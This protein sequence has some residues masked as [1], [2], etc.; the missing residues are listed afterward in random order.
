MVDDTSGD[1]SNPSGHVSV[2]NF[3]VLLRRCGLAV[4]TAQLKEIAKVVTVS[5]G[6]KTRRNLPGPDV[7]TVNYTRFV[8]QIVRIMQGGHAPLHTGGANASGGRSK[9]SAD[10][11][12]AFEV[13]LGQLSIED[14][15]GEEDYKGTTLTHQQL[16][17]K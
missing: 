12:D 1:E 9:A 10:D 2:T 3:Y 8:P 5:T 13:A 7:A 11:W 6:G 17:Y 15:G 14:G 4:T 16:R